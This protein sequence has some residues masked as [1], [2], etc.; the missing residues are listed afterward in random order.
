MSGYD[1]TCD[2]TD[3]CASSHVNGGKTISSTCENLGATK[4]TSVW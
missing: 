3:D 1:C 4:V 2:D